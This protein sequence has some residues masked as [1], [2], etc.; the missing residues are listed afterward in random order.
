MTIEYPIELE[1]AFDDVN[2]LLN[3]SSATVNEAS[4]EFFD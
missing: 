2:I 1:G 4:D 3:Q